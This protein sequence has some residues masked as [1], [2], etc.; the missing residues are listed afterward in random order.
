MERI[1]HQHRH[2]FALKTYRTKDARKYYETESDAFKRLRH[3]NRP[4][5]NIIAFYGGFERENMYNIIL[6]YADGGSLD[7]FME[8]TPAPPDSNQLSIFWNQ[9]FNILN[10]LAIIHGEGS[11]EGNGPH[12]LLGWHQD[13]NPTNILVKSRP[14]VSCPYDVH[15]KIADLGL[16]H[17]KINPSGL[18][19]ATD[20]DTFGTR[21]YGAP[22]TYRNDFHMENSTLRVKQDVDIWSTGCVLSEVVTWVSQGWDKVLDYRRRRLEE[23]YQLSRQREDCFHNGWEDLLRTVHKVHHEDMERC[24]R[25]DELTQPIIKSLIYEMLLNA[26]QHRPNARYLYQKSKRIMNPHPQ[27]PPPKRP[28]LG[29]NNL[30]GGSNYLEPN[31]S[32][33]SDAMPRT[34]SGSFHS[35]SSVQHDQLQREYQDPNGY[36][37]SSPDETGYFKPVHGTS[38]EYGQPRRPNDPATL[39]PTSETQSTLAKRPEDLKLPPKLSVEEGLDYINN[40]LS[41]PDEHLMEELQGRDHAFLVDNSKS[42]G[43]YRLQMRKV[44]ELLARKVENGDSSRLDL[45]FTAPYRKLKRQNTNAILNEFDSTDLRDMPDMRS[46]L[47]RILDEY[48]DPNGYT[49]SSPDET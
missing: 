15:F 38:R 37:P 9:F 22:E 12:M 49:P 11:E 8:R 29:H 28:P 43:A 48:Q 31:P 44:L 19:K 24:P 30:S 7:E 6:E 5:Q 3:N 40:K 26:N 25:H 13:I 42:S 17:F 27:S 1:H 35:L 41:F 14:N 32:N 4:P 46:C 2:T 20:K 47:A 34:R 16:S 21:A 23:R 10:G 33:F 36:T 45:Y 39:S 18:G